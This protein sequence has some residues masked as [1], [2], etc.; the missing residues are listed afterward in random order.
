MVIEPMLAELAARF[1]PDTVDIK[2]PSGWA[3][4]QCSSSSRRGGRRPGATPNCWSARR[5]RS[6]ERRWRSRSSSPRPPRRPRSW[7]V[8]ATC[9][10]S[11]RPCRGTPSAPATTPTRR[12]SL[13]VRHAQRLLTRLLGRPPQQPETKSGTRPT[14]SGCR[15]L[16]AGAASTR[17]FTQDDARW[18]RAEM[19]TVFCIA[20]E[21]ARTRSRAQRPAASA[22]T[23]PQPVLV[24]RAAMP[25]ANIRRGARLPSD[26]ET[27][28][29]IGD[30]RRPTRWFDSALP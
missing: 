4:P 8:T 15:S 7:P 9:R 25:K 14:N 17:N 5:L 26:R 3:T 2:T 16:A 21:R 18:P 24:P 27:G 30:I 13:P 28:T 23:A 12:R 29:P 22:H 11:Q 1:D 6:C 10:H 19:V 20:R